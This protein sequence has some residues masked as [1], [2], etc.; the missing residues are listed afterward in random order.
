[1]PNALAP[2]PLAVAVVPT[3]VDHGPVEFVPV[4][5]AI[6]SKLKP[7]GA[8]PLA[9]AAAPIAIGDPCPVAFALALAPI[10]TADPADEVADAFVPTAVAPPPEATL[11]VPA[12]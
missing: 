6:A 3:A 4:P 2:V 8:V 1:M 7:A 12:L 10:A 9:F 5:I 11:P